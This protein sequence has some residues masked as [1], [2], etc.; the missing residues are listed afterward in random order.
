MN[1]R[2]DL[3]DRPPTVADAA[4]CQMPR[5]A[6]PSV[7]LRALTSATMTEYEDRLE[8]IEK[9]ERAARDDAVAGEQD[10]TGVSEPEAGVDINDATG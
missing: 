6:H 3:P 5:L 7:H 4:G 2:R 1:Y 9:E 8:A 10:L